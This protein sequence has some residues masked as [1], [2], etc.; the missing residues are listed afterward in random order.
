MRSR[1]FT[2][3]MGMLV[4]LVPSAWGLEAVRLKNG[5]EFTVKSHQASGQNVRFETASGTIEVRSSEVA[6]IERFADGQQGLVRQ[7]ASNVPQRWLTLL[8]QLNAAAE[9]QGNAP[10]FRRLVRSIATV[11]SGLNPTAVSPKGAIGLMQLMP[12]T[13]RIL[14]VRAQDVEQNALGGAKLLAQLLELYHY[15]AVKAIAAYNAGERAVQ[16]YGGVPPYAE[17]QNYVRK[18]LRVYDRLTAAES[19]QVASVA[20][21]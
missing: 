13:A 2:A 10:E 20:T 18:V 1:W 11:E 19:K 4:V 6:S 5:F 14:G 12:E 17:T 21:P 9:K 8:E 7:P 15:D 16:R 3:W